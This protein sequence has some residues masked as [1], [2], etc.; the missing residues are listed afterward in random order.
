MKTAFRI[1]AAVL[2]L[3][4]GC[5]TAAGPTGGQFEMFDMAVA[6]D[7][8]VGRYLEVQGQGVTRTC[9]FSFSGTLRPDGRADVTARGPGGKQARGALSLRGDELRLDLPRVNDF[10]GCS[11]PSGEALQGSR[12]LTAA[13]IDLARI[14]VPRAR[15]RANPTGRMTPRFVVQGDLVGVLRRQGG[16]MLVEYASGEGKPV[17]GWIATSEARSIG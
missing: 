17:Q 13:W 16:A 3:A 14:T 7:R 11:V 15:F 12:T 5:A 6:G 1:A 10:G 4:P 9:T 2:A 8:I